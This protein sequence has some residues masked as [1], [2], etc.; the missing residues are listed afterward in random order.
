MRRMSRESM[1]REAQTS[2]EIVPHIE[3][4]SVCICSR[5]AGDMPSRMKG[6]TALLYLQAVGRKTSAR[7]SSLSN[8]PLKNIVLDERPYNESPPSGWM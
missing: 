1:P 6:S 8:S 3:S 7:R 5:L 4:T 2:E